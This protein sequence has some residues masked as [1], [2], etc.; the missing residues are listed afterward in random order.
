MS[1]TASFWIPN[2][3]TGS[4]PIGGRVAVADVLFRKLEDGYVG[5]FVDAETECHA[6][7]L[8]WERDELFG[9]LSISCG[10]I[11]ARA[12]DNGLVSF[13]TFNFSSSRARRE[14]AKEIAD[15]VRARGPQLDFLG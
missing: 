4:R 11:G 8:R 10:L 6:D 1:F 9:Q 15:R 7:R 14:R 5:T 2:S 3:S 13:G 12:T